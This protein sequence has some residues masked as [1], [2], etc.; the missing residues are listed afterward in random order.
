MKQLVIVL[1]PLTTATGT[2]SF[3]E[4]LFCPSSQN[5]RFQVQF[6]EL[7]AKS[8]VINMKLT[9]RIRIVSIIR[10]FKHP[11]LSIVLNLPHSAQVFRKRLPSR[12]CTSLPS[13]CLL[14]SSFPAV[15]RSSLRARRFRLKLRF[16]STFGWCV[17]PRPLYCV[18]VRSTFL[19]SKPR[20]LLN[21][22]HEDL[23]LQH[24]HFCWSK[25]VCQ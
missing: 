6:D 5:I 2:T 14:P 7:M 10:S 20:R 17:L 1:N 9:R 13:T 3:L 12:P 24:V 22:R 4:H 15:L 16:V 21:G 19:L 25:E 18:F 8:V 11:N 23:S